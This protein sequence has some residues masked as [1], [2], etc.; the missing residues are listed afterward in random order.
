MAVKPLPRERLR[1]LAD[2]TGHGLPTLA[3]KL[4]Y[5]SENS[6]RQCFAG[7]QTMPAD[8]TSWLERYAQFRQQWAKAEEAWTQKNPPPIAD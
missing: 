5:A 2:M 4:G 1:E 8:K 7:K 6:L 3:R